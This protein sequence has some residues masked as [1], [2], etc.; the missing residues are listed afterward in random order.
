MRNSRQYHSFADLLLKWCSLLNVLIR[1][2]T[3]CDQSVGYRA[4]FIYFLSKCYY[5]LYE[6]VCACL[7]R[8]VA[9]FADLL[10]KWHSL[11]NVLVRYATIC[12]QSLSY[13]AF[14]FIS[15]FWIARGLFKQYSIG[16][17]LILMHVMLDVAAYSIFTL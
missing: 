11:F 4:F 8:R 2:A 12:D 14:F 6:Y 16:D 9:S 17:Q 5:Y 13:W 1:Y 15:L 7:T 10:L 3:I